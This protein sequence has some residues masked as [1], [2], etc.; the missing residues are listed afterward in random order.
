MWLVA[1]RL[2]STAI[3]GRGGGWGENGSPSLEFLLVEPSYDRLDQEADPAIISAF[4]NWTWNHEFVIMGF[5]SRTSQEFN[6]VHLQSQRQI[7]LLF[8]RREGQAASTQDLPW[9]GHFSRPTDKAWRV[10]VTLL[11]LNP[12]ATEVCCGLKSNQSWWKFLVLGRGKLSPRWGR[13]WTIS[14]WGGNSIFIKILTSIPF[15][16]PHQ[17]T[18]KTK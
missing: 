6:T 3:V 12:R 2:K 1:A 16:L 5:N 11:E 4:G 13:R 18:T 14:L 10:W 17:K 15:L 9:L 8:W 7:F